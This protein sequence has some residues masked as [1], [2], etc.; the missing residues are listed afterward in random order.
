MMKNEILVDAELLVK[1]FA[2]E[3]TPE[4]AIAI[5]NWVE[6]SQDNRNLYNELENAWE[7]GRTGARKTPDKEIAWANL[8]TVLKEKNTPRIIPFRFNYKIAASILLFLT[9]G[10]VAY[11]YYFKTPAPVE[12]VIASHRKKRT[13]KEVEKVKLADGTSVTINRNSTLE[14]LDNFN[15]KSREVSLAGEAFFDVAHNPEKPFIITVDEVQVKV[16]GTAFNV[17]STDSTTTAEV[18]RGKVMMY[19][20]EKQ[21]IL[22]AGM[23]GHYDKETKELSVIKLT[24]ENG[25]AYVTHS[26]SFESA[27]LKEVCEQ[28][29]KAYGVQFVLSTK[30]KGCT[31][32][33]EYHDKSL[34]FILSVI[35]ESLGITYEIKDN[36]VYITGDGCL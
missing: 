23:M 28:L 1:F 21:I 20:S 4:E 27:S 3:A 5:A 32:T 22:E 7:L 34:T 9:A 10:L 11:F 30:V 31:L 26:L 14:W 35:S 17:S 15:T 25:I 2:G 12:E 36:I 6:Q 16:L 8:Q 13:S 18:I 29:S 24:N 19:T 33:S